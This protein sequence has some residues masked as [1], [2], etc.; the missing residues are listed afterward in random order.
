MATRV[1]ARLIRG[2]LQCVRSVIGR[3]TMKG[4]I[5]RTQASLVWWDSILGRTQ[6]AKTTLSRAMDYLLRGMSHTPIGVPIV[7]ILA[8]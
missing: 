5:S 7:L 1:E 8:P 4:N 2:N 6:K 3:A